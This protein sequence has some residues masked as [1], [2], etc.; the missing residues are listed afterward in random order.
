MWASSPSETL[1]SW[2][3]ALVSW[4][5]EDI[6][7]AAAEDC[8]ATEAIS[9]EVSAM[10]ATRS[11]MPAIASPISTN[12]CWARSELPT[13]SSARC[14]A[15]WTRPTTVSMPCW[16]SWMRSA[17][18][19]AES[20]GLLGE[21]ADL[22]GDDGEAAAVLAGAGRLDGGVEREQ[23]GL[24]GDAGDRVQDPADLARLARELLDA[25]LRLLT[26]DADAL[27]DV[28]GG[29][30]G[31][32]AEL[33]ELAGPRGGRRGLVGELA[34][35]LEHR[36]LLL[37]AAGDLGAGLGD[38]VHGV[39]GLLDALAHLREHLV[40]ALAGV[41]EQVQRLVDRGLQLGAAIG[42]VVLAATALDLA[43]G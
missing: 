7:W 39:A 10:P 32:G 25:G 38:P 18:E 27:H 28:V 34:V 15:C 40:H 35:A 41:D 20:P 6:S 29:S 2:D 17:I 22:L 13:P 42:Q 37:G 30:D 11:E 12:A 9:P 21:A 36:R 1:T 19:V 24:V 16:I 14:A 4:V 31:L 5:A 3:C 23:V 33:A 43:R 26:G 8:S